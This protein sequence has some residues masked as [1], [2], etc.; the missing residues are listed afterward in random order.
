LKKL[1]IEQEKAWTEKKKLSLGDRAS[2]RPEKK[3]DRTSKHSA[4]KEEENNA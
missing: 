2:Q 4:K 1:K 3:K